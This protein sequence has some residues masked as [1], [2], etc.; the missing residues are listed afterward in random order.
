ML[1][2]VFTCEWRSLYECWG[3]F[4]RVSGDLFCVHIGAS[5][6]C[7][8]RLFFV[9]LIS[10]FCV[11]VEVHVWRPFLRVC[12]DILFCARAE[13]SFACVWMSFLHVCGE[14]LFAIMSFLCVLRSRVLRFVL[15]V[16]G[17]MWRFLFVHAESSFAFMSKSLLAAF[18]VRTCVCVC[19]CVC[20]W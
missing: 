5:F 16:S 17:D 14:F 8:L 15:C 7:A 20:V 4:L 11:C 19:V 1:G 6:A 3:L 12:R 13:I 9:C 2:I 18:V 10:I